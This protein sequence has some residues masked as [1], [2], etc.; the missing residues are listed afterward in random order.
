MPTIQIHG[1]ELP[2]NAADVI[3]FDD[4][5]IGLPS[6]RQMVLVGQSDITPFLWLASLDDSE[7]AFLVVEPHSLF[8]QY[9]PLISDEVRTGI[10][11]DADNSPSVLNIVSISADWTKSTV[12]LRAPLFINASSMRGAQSA[13]VSTDYKLT[14]PLPIGPDSTASDDSI[15]ADETLKAARAH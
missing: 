6:L 14:Q 11:L 15:G 10:S 2:Y 1:T 12:N 13:L 9:L 8:D 7:T 3:T 5:L 4:G